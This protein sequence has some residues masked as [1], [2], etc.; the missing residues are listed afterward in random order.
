MPY[1]KVELSKDNVEWFETHYPKASFS[2][3]LDLL[4]TAFR[5]AQTLTPTDYAAIAA[6][7]INRDIKEEL[8]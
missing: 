2:W 5:E 6:A 7:Q 1:K 3:V 8:I 4:M